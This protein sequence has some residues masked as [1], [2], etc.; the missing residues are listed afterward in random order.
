[1]STWLV[2]TWRVSEM[3][4]VEVPHVDD[5]ARRR[6]PL[7]TDPQQSI[8]PAQTLGARLER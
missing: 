6:S 7:S 5:G 4:R 8:E 3:A 1:V 2:S